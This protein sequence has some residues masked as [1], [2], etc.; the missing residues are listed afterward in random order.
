MGEADEIN[1]LK[2]HLFGIYY[3]FEIKGN[4]SVVLP[5]FRERHVKELC[6]VVVEPLRSRGD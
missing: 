5:T 1:C 6:F 3:V 2:D 4:V